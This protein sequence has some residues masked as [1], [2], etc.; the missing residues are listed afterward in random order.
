MKYFL[1]GAFASALFL[2]GIALIYGYSGSLR[3]SDIATAT[4]T[5]TGME[6]LL[7]VGAVLILSGLL[8]KVGA[9]PFHTWT[10]GR[11]PGR[12]DA[13]HRLHGRVHQGRRVRRAA[14]DR[15]HGVPRT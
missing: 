9:V 5:P 13:D 2:F 11:L 15:L 14:A 3:Y 8:F 6:S 12:A 7:L 10:P 1:L 4:G